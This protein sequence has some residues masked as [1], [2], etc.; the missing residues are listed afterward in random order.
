MD[1]AQRWLQDLL[2]GKT[3]VRILRSLL[4]CVCFGNRNAERSSGHACT[5]SQ[6]SHFK[7]DSNIDNNGI[8][9]Q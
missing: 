6:L 4:H 9:S 7:C 5:P 3:V 8:N 1:L 2:A